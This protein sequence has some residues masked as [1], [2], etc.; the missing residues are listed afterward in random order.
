MCGVSGTPWRSRFLSRPRGQ[1]ITGIYFPVASFL[2]TDC[3][4]VYVYL[5]V[6]R[7]SCRA[8]YLWN[9]HRIFARFHVL[10]WG[11]P[12]VICAVIISTNHAGYMKQGA[13][14]EWCWITVPQDDDNDDKDDA[15]TDTKTTTQLLVPSRP[16]PSRPA[17]T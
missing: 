13:S 4:A 10:A 6:T 11:F 15:T 3:I 12:M 8:V 1:A 14:G 7:M 9:P 2:W 16:V 5:V 17:L